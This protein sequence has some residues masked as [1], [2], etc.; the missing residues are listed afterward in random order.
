MNPALSWD[1][2]PLDEA[3]ATGLAAANALVA[4]A[5]VTVGSGAM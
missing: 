5:G 3:A 4:V 2:K 1:R